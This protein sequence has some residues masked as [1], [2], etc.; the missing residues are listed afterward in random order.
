MFNLANLGF[1][2]TSNFIPELLI[3][4]AMIESNMVLAIVATVSLLFAPI[5]SLWLYTRVIFGI[6]SLS[7]VKYYTD[8]SRREFLLLSSLI[9]IILIMGF[10]PSIVFQVFNLNC[11]VLV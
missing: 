11:A 10:F 2:G 7:A 3:F 1:P 8:L 5:Y 4:I 6:P 9:V